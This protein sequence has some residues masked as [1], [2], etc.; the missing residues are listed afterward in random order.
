M[1]SFIFCKLHKS[2]K[3]YYTIFI[4]QTA[5]THTQYLDFSNMAVLI[6]HI[7][8]KGIQLCKQLEGYQVLI[9]GGLCC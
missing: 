7:H 4:A 9:F 5:C 3:I 6:P 1:G 8:A 2:A